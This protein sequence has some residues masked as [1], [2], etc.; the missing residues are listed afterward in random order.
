M[1]KT[2]KQGEGV[3][4]FFSRIGIESYIE[5]LQFSSKAPGLAF[6]FLKLFQRHVVN[7]F[8]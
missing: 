7:Y 5:S 2:Y 8:G 4:F 6:F 3:C 1:V